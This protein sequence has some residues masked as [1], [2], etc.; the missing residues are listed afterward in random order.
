MMQKLL[1]I[2]SFSL[3]AL[4]CNAQCFLDSTFADSGTNIVNEEVFVANYCLK[5]EANEKDTISKE[6]RLL[7]KQ[8]LFSLVGN[9]LYRNLVLKKVEVTDWSGLENLVSQVPS[10]S[11]CKNIKYLFHYALV[12]EDWIK[13][14]LMIPVDKKNRIIKKGLAMPNIDIKKDLKYS[15]YC[16]AYDTLSSEIGDTIFS[17]EKVSVA[18]DPSKKMMDWVFKQKRVQKNTSKKIKNISFNEARFE[19]FIWKISFCDG[20]IRTEKVTTLSRQD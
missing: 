17:I 13:Y 19:Y 9:S 1:W 11:K 4:T 7:V 8:Y 18:Y 6:T 20:A 15:Q 10:K 3:L 5:R 14:E 16:K 12:F 2:I